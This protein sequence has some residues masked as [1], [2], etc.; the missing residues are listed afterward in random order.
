MGLDALSRRAIGELSGGE[1][2]CVM[3]GRAIVSRPQMLILDEPNTYVDQKFESKLYDLLR[4]INQDTAVVLVS[5]DVGTMLSLIKNITY[6]SC[7][8]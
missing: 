7:R 3:L 6:T 2:Q 8:L 1:L 5:H 4:E